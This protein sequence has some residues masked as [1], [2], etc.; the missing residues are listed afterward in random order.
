MHIAS[1]LA[2]LLAPAPSAAL[3][4]ASPTAPLRAAKTTAR[5]VSC[6]SLR[7]ET[8][9]P[10]PAGFAG[11]RALLAGA[12][13]AL[14][15]PS[16]AFAE[17]IL[18]MDDDLSAPAEAQP[19]EEAKPLAISVVSVEEARWGTQSSGR[20]AEVLRPLAQSQN[21]W[22]TYQNRWRTQ[23]SGRPAQVQYGHRLIAKG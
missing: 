4:L 9:L 20:P 19:I 11:R 18:K 7:V 16:T 21:H 1:L 2:L 6:A 8:Q 22:K 3:L 13:V 23:S 10:A 5:A 14:A 12:L 17:Q 15:A